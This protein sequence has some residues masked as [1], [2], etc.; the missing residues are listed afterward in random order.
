MSIVGWAIG[1]TLIA[2]RPMTN[3]VIWWCG[4]RMDYSLGFPTGWDHGVV[5]KGWE[6]TTKM[7]LGYFGAPGSLIGQNSIPTL[8]PLKDRG[9]WNGLGP[10]RTNWRGLKELNL[11]IKGR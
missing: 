1:F 3:S 5:D 7:A 11:G 6:L 9:P 10:L 4:L 8:V 2:S